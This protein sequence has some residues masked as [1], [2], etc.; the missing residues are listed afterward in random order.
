MPN[1]INT[2]WHEAHK[3]PPKATLEQR[4]EWHLEHQRECQCRTDLPAGIAFELAR[5]AAEPKRP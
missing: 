4:V 5:R 1:K 2:V 3:M